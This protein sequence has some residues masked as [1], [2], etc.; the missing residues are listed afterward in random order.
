MDKTPTQA[1]FDNLV[2]KN[3]WPDFKSKGYRKTGNNFRLYNA[4]GWGKIVNI[5]KSMY[6]E[7]HD[8]CFT[9]NVGLYLP[10]ADTIFETPRGEKFLEPDCL[11]RKRI[12][13]I[14]GNHTDTWYDLTE[15]TPASELETTVQNDFLR[16]IFPYLEHIQS[17]ND[18]IKQ[19]IQEHWP[20]EENTIRTLFICGYEDEARQWIEVEI[21]TTI[22]RTW[23]ER[24]VRLKN[25]LI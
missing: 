23:R 21:S 10:E 19:I 22:Y 9:V 15:S 25:S 18:I 13:H 14:S 7:K 4:S 8:I 16:F 11:V 5:Q 2:S 24:L 3:L 6:S 17:R 20:N 12:G 1:R